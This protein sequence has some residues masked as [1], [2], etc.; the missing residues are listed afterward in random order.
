GLLSPAQ[1]TFEISLLAEDI[2]GQRVLYAGT[3]GEDGRRY[4]GTSPDAKVMAYDPASGDIQDYGTQTADA[5]YVFG[6]GI[7]DGRIWAGTGPVPHLLE[8][9]PDTGERSELEPP[10]HVMDGTD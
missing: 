1:A 2:G 10:E 3:I 9:D 4:G 5:D 7:V 6:L 8:I